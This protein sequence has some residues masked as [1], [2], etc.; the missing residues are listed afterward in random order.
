MRTGLEGVPEDTEEVPDYIEAG[1]VNRTT[2]KR[3]DETDPAAITEYFPIKELLPELNYI[4]AD[5]DTLIP[6]ELVNGETEDGNPLNTNDTD[7]EGEDTDSPFSSSPQDDA[8]SIQQQER[9]IEQN[10]EATEELF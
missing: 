8:N 4:S 6:D 10:N 3:T 1:L 2:G 9:I 5:S 7:L